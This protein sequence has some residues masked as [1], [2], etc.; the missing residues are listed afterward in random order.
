MMHPNDIYNPYPEGIFF[1]LHFTGREECSPGHSYRGIRNHFLIHYVEKGNGVV[2]NSSNSTTALEAGNCFLFPPHSK[3][4][5]RASKEKPWTYRWLAFSAGPRQRILSLPVSSH[6]VIFRSSP[7]DE[8]LSLMIKIMNHFK[9]GDRES[10]GR[11]EEKFLQILSTLI[12]KASTPGSLFQTS[13]S[14]EDTQ[15][16]KPDYVEAAREYIHQ[17]Y[18]HNITAGIIA[19]Y[20][21]L[22]RSYF[23]RLFSRKAGISLRDYLIEYRMKQACRLLKETDFTVQAIAASVGYTNYAVFS[24][25]FKSLKGLSAGEWR[26]IMP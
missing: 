9:N 25:R 5:Y 14:S 22:D 2:G 1:S 10:S 24:R 8:T 16:K 23:S 12:N 7:S 3:I 20:I 17:N 13:Q 26:R 6:P 19:E 11:C 18:Q 4:Y 15:K 21:G